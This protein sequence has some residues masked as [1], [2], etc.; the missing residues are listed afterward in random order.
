[1]TSTWRIRPKRST[2]DLDTTPSPLTR[3]SDPLIPSGTVASRVTYLQTLFGPSS[4][5]LPSPVSQRRENS[6]TGFG[7][8]E[9]PRFGKPASRNSGVDEQS[10][11]DAHHHF[12]GLSTPRANHREEHATAS[13][14]PFKQTWDKTAGIHSQIQPKGLPG[15]TQQDAISPWAILPQH[16]H[17]NGF[18]RPSV[19]DLEPLPEG[20]SSE[21]RQSTQ[22]SAGTASIIFPR[23][24]VERPTPA[25]LTPVSLKETE[26][27]T[28]PKDALYEQN[29][30][31]SI[32][33][34]STMRRQSVRD[35]YERYGIGRPSGLASRDH[36]MEDM[37]QPSLKHRYC[38]VCSWINGPD[39]SCWR[40]GHRFCDTCDDLS[41]RQRAQEWG[42]STQIDASEESSF[43][44]SELENVTARSE[45]ETP[46][47]IA[48]TP[49]QDAFDPSLIPPTP[50]IYIENP[51]SRRNTRKTPPRVI[52]IPK[53]SSVIPS[54]GT[55]PL[56]S[57]I[58]KDSPFL[59][60]D[61]LTPGT[62]V[63]P[64]RKRKPSA[65]DR[66]ST[67]CS[68]S[69]SFEED[70]CDSPTCR[71][72][73]HGHRPY[74]HSISCTE[75]QRGLNEADG[76]YKASAG[77]QPIVSS[78]KTA[79][80][81]GLHDD[82]ILPTFSQ[83][84]ENSG[85]SSATKT[86]QIHRHSFKDSPQHHGQLTHFT[87]EAPRDTSR[88]IECRGYPRT[89]DVIQGS[90]TSRGVVG[91]CQHCLND[92]QC[93]ACQN[94]HHS[95]RCCIHEDHPSIKH[96]HLRTL[97]AFKKDGEQLIL[98]PTRPRAK[99]TPSLPRLKSQTTISQY[100]EPQ[101]RPTTQPRP[102][103]QPQHS[104]SDPGLRSSLFT[105]PSKM[106]S[107]VPPA[108]QPDQESEIEKATR[109]KCKG[110]NLLGKSNTTAISQPA[111]VRGLPGFLNPKSFDKGRVTS[112]REEK[113]LEGAEV[114]RGNSGS[115]SGD[116]SETSFQSGGE[117]R[118]SG[119]STAG[120]PCPVDTHQQYNK[121]VP[122]ISVAPH[123]AANE[124]GPRARWAWEGGGPNYSGT[125]KSAQRQRWRLSTVDGKPA[126]SPSHGIS[127]I[128][129]GACESDTGHEG[130]G[131]PV[132]ERK[133]GEMCWT[134][135]Q[136]RVHT[137]EKDERNMDILAVSVVLHL[138]GREDLVVRADLS[139][140]V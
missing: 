130:G 21:S 140:F 14:Q 57:R 4:R 115:V 96:H 90:P 94:A 101:I 22:D 68:I 37:P 73:H 97:Q 128:R 125:D 99:D 86:S 93:E 89:G 104:P 52:E 64:R 82:P 59:I 60:A 88:Y 49:H 27:I 74:R 103:S 119:E 71:A 117:L 79:L 36:S 126:P 67:D 95:V 45:L 62:S 121:H 132:K 5:R 87:T 24:D 77:D 7:K 55:T 53:A 91:K 41:P 84:H 109:P 134:Q 80:L 72:T 107:L 35:L 30:F 78:S 81:H 48:T 127:G 9:N 98:P 17:A 110:K 105:M 100:P 131:L 1:M 19:I 34:T 20:G 113:D 129:R 102:L 12:L 42:S 29:S 10:Q 124:Q 2:Y 108:Q 118:A 138:D 76:R 61:A 83:R 69:S 43:L 85:S 38:H 63:S 92:C 23:S 39:T 133:E 70:N 120:R 106:T 56:T 112:T 139:R 28:R 32:E 136:G 51:T 122:R 46:T 6:R 66:R 15:R 3:D 114:R 11:S 26:K 8:R 54:T 25:L 135:G 137:A 65:R 18:R 16:N 31:D 116:E 58:V 13:V 50:M 47:L 40:C 33:T 75:K 44:S 123:T 111:Q